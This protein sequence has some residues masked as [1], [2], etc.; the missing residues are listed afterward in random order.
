MQSEVLLSIVVA[1]YGPPTASELFFVKCQKHLSYLSSDDTEIIFVLTDP[2]LT[3]PQLTQNLEHEFENVRIILLPDTNLPSQ[4]HASGAAIAKGDHLMF[5]GPDLPF[6]PSQIEALVNACRNRRNDLDELIAVSDQTK[7]ED[8]NLPHAP[9]PSIVHGWL[10]NLPVLDLSNVCI[11]TVAFRA[12]GGFDTSPILQVAYGW[13]LLI[14][15]TANNSVHIASTVRN[16]RVPNPYLNIRTPVRIGA[17]LVKRYIAR[18]PI[19]A[20]REARFVSDLP[21]IEREHLSRLTGLQSHTPLG[22]STI[23]ITITGSFWE[24]HHN[25]LCFLNYLHRLEGQGV[26]THKNVFD[27]TV[28]RSDIEQSDL[29]ILSRCKVEQI[30]DIL[31]WCEE[32]NVPSI[33]MIDDNWLTVG[34]DWPDPY[35][36]IFSPGAPFYENFLYGAQNADYVLTYND[37]LREDIEPYAKKV[38]TLP[39][40]VDLAA[41]EITARRQSSRYLIGYSGSPRYS[42]APFKALAE[43][44]R[45]NKNVDVLLFGTLHQEHEDAL[46]GC[47]LRRLPQTSYARYAE[48]IR[49]ESPDILLAPMDDSRTSRSKCPNKYLEITAA[50]AVGIYSKVEPY[51]WYVQNGINGAFVANSDYTADWVKAITALLDKERLK[52]MYAVAR[53]DVAT[54]YSVPV[55]APQFGKLLIDVANRNAGLY[56]SI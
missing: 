19:L 28:T 49:S 4:M 21:K 37:L 29:V 42:S 3:I 7:I 26:A 11:P 10:V 43:V 31:K 55:V 41:F 18:S 27:H 5:L 54:N 13:D 34:R 33:Y 30:R 53:E 9:S 22:A 50:G 8:F 24:H 1:I 35:K 56:P 47:S 2:R 23:R 52:Q 40:S 15:I 46:K 38:V 45:R 44:A 14:R 20:G 36:L 17:D 6:S 25:W 12:V 51:T 48:M 32:L 39:N 16:E